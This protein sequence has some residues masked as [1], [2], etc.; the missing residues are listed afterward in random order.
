MVGEGVGAGLPRPA[1][2]RFQP[3][4][5]GLVNLFRY[6]DQQFGFEDGHL[7]LRGN[8]GTGKSR[9]LALQLPFLLDGEVAPH[10]MEP[11]GDPAKR[12]EWNLLLGGRY[13]DR[14]GYTWLELGRLAPGT[15]RG[16]EYV[17][18]GCGLS[19]AAGRGLVGRWFFITSKRIGRDLHLVTGAGQALSRERLGEALGESGIVYS[20]AS[21][22][23]E[24]VDQA[25]FRLGKARYEA[26]VNL[27][28]Q[29]RQPQLSRQLDEARLS[30]ALS[31]ALPPL[32]PNL[33]ADV[34]D[35]FRALEADRDALEGF[36]SASRAVEQFLAEYRRYA[37]IAARRRASAVR[38]RH[39]AYEAAMRQLRDAEREIEQAAREQA[40]VEDRVA[41]AR[42]E[43][44]AAAATADALG[45]S[46]AMQDAQAL[47]RA[48]EA[49]ERA[50][51]D[52]DRA[53][54]EAVARAERREEGEREVARARS[55]LDA[56]TASLAELGRRLDQAAA[57]AGI[58]GRHLSAWSPLPAGSPDDEAR[59]EGVVRAL[60]ALVEERRRSLRHLRTLEAALRKSEGLLDQARGASAT[61]EAD[62][63]EAA[64]AQREAAAALEAAVGTLRDRYRA[65]VAQ[66]RELAPPP[67][68]ELVDALADWA[69]EPEG[70]SPVAREVAS[71]LALCLEGLAERRAEAERRLRDRQSLLE[72]LRAEQ[73][74]LES[75]V[76]RP[77]DPPTTRGPDVRTGREGAPFWQVVD[78]AD[79]LPAEHRAALE[80]ALEA[81]G[82]LDAWVSP[83]GKL[84][85]PGDHDILLLA[86]GPEI[87]GGRHLGTVLRPVPDLPSDAALA[88][89]SPESAESRRPVVT[90]ELVAAL[91][92][93]IALGE[94]GGESRDDLVMV[95]LEGRFRL[96]PL[97]GRYAKPTAEHVGEG[98]RQ[99][100]RRRRL[101]ALALEIRQAAE[102]AQAIQQ[103]LAALGRR[104]AAARA[105]AAAAPDDQPI[106]VAAAELEVCGRR[107]DALRTR[108]AEA[109]RRVLE[110]EAARVARRSAFEEAGRDLGLL[111]YLDNLSELEEVLAR[112]AA[113]VAALPPTLRNRRSAYGRSEAAA[114]VVARAVAEL[115]SAEARLAELRGLAA[116]LAAERDV[117]ESSVGAAAEEILARFAEAQ[118]L[119]KVVRA[120]RDRLAGEERKALERA[121]R[122]GGARERALAAVETEQAGRELAAAAL[123]RLGRTRLLGVALP[124]LAADEAAGWSTTRTVEIARAV[125]AAL[126]RCDAGDAAWERSNK[127]LFAHV[128]AL[129]QA[130]LP[131]GH[132]AGTTMTDDLL[133]VEVPF[134]GRLHTMA[135]FGEILATEVVSRQTLLG[136]R[137][138]EVIENHLVGEVSLHLH[139]RLHGA[140]SLVREMNAELAARPMSTGMTLRFSWDTLPDGPAGMIEARRRLMRAGGTWSPAEREALGG[141]LQQRIAAERA[142][143]LAGSW[144]DHLA[145]ALDY[146]RWHRFGVERQQDGVWRR[147]TRRTHGTGSGG[148]KAVALTLPQFA[149]AAAHYRSADPRAPRLILLDEVFVGVD[150]DMR[151]K[152]M[153][154]LATFDFD[155]VMTSEREW[156]C[157]SSLPGLA[158]YQLT[159]RPGIDAVGATRFV[160][161]GRE[162]RRVPLEAPGA[163][164][165]AEATGG[166]PPLFA[167]DP[168]SGA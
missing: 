83:D 10:R 48:R 50:R 140:E 26:L 82:I 110:L 108:L 61:V 73:A 40:E 36:R 165:R 29:L 12:A 85:G 37:Q 141:F 28:I 35:A 138:R 49:A 14:L 39:S 130:L 92:A 56:A 6:D 156:G 104:I 158:I 155:F 3:L 64:A 11:D 88:R 124:Q 27:L 114:R 55:Q 76:H 102:E 129:E 80:A 159:T 45:A 44:E 167:R 66:A 57:R 19:A 53:T 131:Q 25:L 79:G 116:G 146:R 23:R 18:L 100:A 117:L 153:G 109:Q 111:E 166:E 42:V 74:A 121:V 91:L 157:Y 4:R 65:F 148:E 154:L 20:T 113:E 69:A 67:L 15:E 30:E 46:P 41:R 2:D 90:L 106:R 43:E 62:T 136:A 125:E 34:A 168:E 17:T 96:G 87:A 139:D 81:A 47:R 93:R 152:C 122:A 54:L 164:A 118:R 142:A 144:Q 97:A 101:E 112:Y 68:E 151:A 161:D 127:G 77:P 103:E 24:G 143:N 52:V 84:L 123:V 38:A 137:E 58:G 8:N 7:L 71:A 22:Y 105:E 162:R 98:A 70:A 33:I 13:P 31:Q 32:A 1:R 21:A 94:A 5:G 150:S 120:L 99:A 132:Q 126:E 135:E 134:Q 149:A 147:L 145:Q 59:D 107:L 60:A 119:V 16:E 72:G 51:L 89:S 86:A 128:Q 75:G 9:V 133:V 78:F 163:R 115:A 95:D 160:W 63:D